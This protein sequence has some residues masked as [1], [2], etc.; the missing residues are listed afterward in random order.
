MKK[1]TITLL[2]FIVATALMAQLSVPNAFNYQAVVRNTEGEIIANQD[3][4]FKFSILEDPDSGDPVYVETHSALTN[5]FGLVNLKIGTGTVISGVLD[6]G[7][8]S[9]SEHFLKVEIDPSGGNSFSLLGISHLLSVPYAFHAQTVAEDMVED[10][11]ADP[12]NELQELFISNDTIYLTHDG[13]HVKLPSSGTGGDDWGTQTVETNATLAGDGTSSSPLKIARQGANTGQ[14]LLWSGSDWL[15]G[16]VSGGGT[17]LWQQNGSDI[18]YNSGNVGIGLNNP[19][20]MLEINGNGVDSYPH[21]LL[22]ELDDYARISFRTMSS[23]AK[24]W[25]LSGWTDPTD[26]VSQFHIHYN[27]GSAGK[28]IITLVGDSRAIFHGNVGIGTSNPGAKLD[29]NGQIKITGG[30]PDVGRVLTSDASGLASWQTNPWIKSG[31]NIYYN[32]GK[33]GIGTDPAVYRL[34]I[35]DDQYSFARFTNSASGNANNDGFYIG[36]SPSGGSPV[37]IWNFE[38]SNIHFATNNTRRLDIGADGNVTIMKSLNINELVPEGKALF[39]NGIEALWYNGTYFSWGF[40]ASHNYFAKPV[41]IKTNT[42]ADYELVVNGEAAKTGG[43]DWSNPSD[44]RLK[45]VLGNYTRGLNDIIRLQPVR[46]KYKVD[47]PRKLPSD[48][49]QIGFI[50]QEV[51]DVFPEAVN[52]C[53]DGYF[54]FNMHSVNVALVNSVKE[55]KAE[56][57]RLKSEIVRM[58]SEYESRI[59]RLENM[60]SGYTENNK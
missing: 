12:E 50:A 32:N 54:D 9:L 36:N 41:G 24:H 10:A 38:N 46:F 44:I 33:V 3:V 1:F 17:S 59:S 56:N 7:G 2:F 23:S 8:W 60:V 6:P 43:G 45:D 31:D 58:R 5:G 16:N 25:V 13:G 57:D 39:V 20:G 27:N 21:L 55:L 22:S 51:Q 26:A 4:K 40:G 29:I 49:E 34:E 18:F 42:M 30:N 19:S 28:N 11:D 48:L 35:Y 52:Q 47:N 37:W 14:A 15:P 53:S